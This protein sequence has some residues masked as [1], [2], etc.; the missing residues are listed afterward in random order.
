MMFPAQLHLAHADEDDIRIRF[1]HSDSSDG[2]AA[3]FAV[4][5]RLPGN[6]AVDGFPES[7]ASRAE[8]VLV[9]ATG[10]FRWR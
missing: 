8:V 9:R 7:A 1:G 6:A 2:G 5:D 4:S 10:A 3:D